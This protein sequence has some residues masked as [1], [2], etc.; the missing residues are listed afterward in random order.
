VVL[1]SI[2]AYVGGIK[3]YSSNTSREEII[4]D[5]DVAYSGDARVVFTLQV[6]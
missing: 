4:L 6:I 3:V 1:G 5:C 2:P